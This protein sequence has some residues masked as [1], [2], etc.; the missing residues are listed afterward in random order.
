[1]TRLSIEE[2]QVRRSQS[3]LRF[4]TR[5]VL[6]SIVPD[7][8]HRIDAGGPEGRNNAGN[9]G[10]GPEKQGDRAE[11]RGIERAHSKE[12]R[13]EKPGGGKGESESDGKSDE[14]QPKPL[15]QDQPAYVGG[16]GAERHADTYLPPPRVTLKARSP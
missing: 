16:P 9:R 8:H 7:C 15:A 13:L 10:D 1:M 6:S 12:E 4:R 2:L 3:R 5:N 11:G 14:G